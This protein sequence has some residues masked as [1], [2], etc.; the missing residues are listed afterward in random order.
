[1]ANYWEKERDFR[2]ETPMGTLVVTDKQDDANPGIWIDLEVMR[3]GVAL[4]VPLTTMEVPDSVI[5]DGK[6]LVEYQFTDPFKDDPT[7][8][9]WFWTDE[10]QRDFIEKWEE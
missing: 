9:V 8:S 10:E 7:N 2:V 5:S 6:Y 3:N 4:R 1:M